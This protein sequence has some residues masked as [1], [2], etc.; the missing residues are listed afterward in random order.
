MNN[1]VEQVC[2]ICGRPVEIGYPQSI[3]RDG[4]TVHKDCFERAEANAKP[5]PKDWNPNNSYT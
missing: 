1:S 4:H 5:K 2:P 3:E